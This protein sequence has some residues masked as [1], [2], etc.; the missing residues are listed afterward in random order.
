MRHRVLKHPHRGKRLTMAKRMRKACPHART[1]SR[2]VHTMRVTAR[3]AHIDRVTQA[4]ARMEYQAWSHAIDHDYQ[5]EQG[6][7]L[8]VRHTPRTKRCAMDYTNVVHNKE[9]EAKRRA[10]QAR[11]HNQA[12]EQ[13]AYARV[14]AR[15][16]SMREDAKARLE[17]TQELL[18]GAKDSL[19][20]A[21]LDWDDATDSGVINRGVAWGRSYDAIMASAVEPRWVRRAA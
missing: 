5:V 10:K 19:S 17:D 16:L 7:R 14:Q 11:A 12:Q 2:R 1:R 15:L 4:Q 20:R 9:L 18:R 8:Y 13:A 3:M 6:A 21:G